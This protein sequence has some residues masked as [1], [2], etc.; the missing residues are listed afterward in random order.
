MNRSLLKISLKIGLATAGLIVLY[1]LSNLL[2]NYHYFK[3]EYYIAGAVILA[4]ITGV[5]LTRRFYREKLQ[6]ID[7][8]N[9]LDDLTAKELRVLELIAVGKSNKEIASLNYTEIST[10]KTHINN[11]FFKLGVKNRKDAAK[12][13]R[14]Q[15]ER[16][17]STFFPPATI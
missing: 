14:Q 8:H 1:E 9:P 6:G 16:Q 11:I 2:L 5:V 15:I 3:F 7:A 17:K 13:F 4:L 10:V 12:V